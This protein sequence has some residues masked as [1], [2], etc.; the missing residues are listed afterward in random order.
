MNREIIDLILAPVCPPIR[1]PDPCNQRKLWQVVDMLYRSPNLNVPVLTFVPGQGRT[2]ITILEAAIVMR[3]PELVSQ[4]LILGANPNVTTAGI[5][6][7]QQLLT[8]CSGPGDWWAEQ[9]IIQILL[10][11]GAWVPPGFPGTMR[12]NRQIRY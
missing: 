6:L 7:V 2:E 4:V 5:P 9:A 3:W 12:W 10:Q 1:G 11:F 8:L